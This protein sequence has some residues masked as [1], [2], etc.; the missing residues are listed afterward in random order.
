MLGPDTAYSKK[1][2]N[3]T[4]GGS[5]DINEIINAIRNKVIW[6]TLWRILKSLKL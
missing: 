6:G 4:N 5:K 2:E 3:N 1:K